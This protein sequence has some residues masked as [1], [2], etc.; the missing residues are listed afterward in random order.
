MSVYHSMKYIKNE[1]RISNI[2]LKS[3]VNKMLL[4]EEARLTLKSPVPGKYSPYLWKESVM[5]RSVV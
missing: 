3:I 1:S 4:S 2:K 5:T